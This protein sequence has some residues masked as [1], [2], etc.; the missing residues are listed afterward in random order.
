MQILVISDSHGRYD[1]MR[2][3][4]LAHGDADMA[5]HCGDGEQDVTRFLEEFPGRRGWLHI[6]RGNC[7]HNDAVPTAM[8]F[9]LPYGHRAFVIHGHE[10]MYGDST[11]RL[12]QLAKGQGAD[13]LFF[14]HSH[15]RSIQTVS[16]VLMVN[17]GSSAQPRDGLPA[18]YVLLDVLPSGI[19]TAF[20][21]V[22]NAS[23]E[24]M[25]VM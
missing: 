1:T 21:E 3:V 11:G 12:V 13:I 16:N 2:D 18:S 8:T 20:E 22:R 10:Q 6:V 9:Q 15:V 23:L 14:G 5:I 17:P 7:D 24:Y 4:L 25:H 19:C